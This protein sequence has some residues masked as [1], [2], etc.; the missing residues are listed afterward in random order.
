MDSSTL[1]IGEYAHLDS[2]LLSLNDSHMDVAGNLTTEFFNSS[3]GTYF[4]GASGDTNIE[5]QRSLIDVGGEF[6][7][8]ID[9][10]LHI[11]L[12]GTGRG[13]EYGAIN[14]DTLNLLGG[15]LSV[16]VGFALTADTYVFDL[17]TSSS[18]DGILGDF[19]SLSVTGYDPG[20]SLFAGI[21][22]DDIG[23]GLGP[24]EIYRLTLSRIDPVPVPAAV[25]LFG[26]GIFGLMGLA[27]RKQAR[28][29]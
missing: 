12:D 14:T 16:E 11:S 6:A 8:G 21:V 4:E 23:I 5:L 10:L 17:I 18:D 1:S 27:R 26:T 19:D 25:W 15:M 20:Y 2:G 22:L 28:S 29:S 24:T 13:T 9:D 3:L 7:L